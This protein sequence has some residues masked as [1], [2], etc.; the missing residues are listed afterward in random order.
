MGEF[1]N[2]AVL[3]V[4]VLCLVYMYGRAERGSGE[5][6]ATAKR[7][8]GSRRRVANALEK[9]QRP[10]PRGSDIARIWRRRSERVRDDEDG[11][12]STVPRS[13]P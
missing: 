3:I 12:D 8:S 7:N 4:L 2:G 10:L 6:V 1:A 11:G 13:E 5:S 9:I